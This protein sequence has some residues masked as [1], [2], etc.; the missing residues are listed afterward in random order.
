[1]KL[2][3]IAPNFEGSD[4]EFERYAMKSMYYVCISYIN[5]YVNNPELSLDNL[6]SDPDGDTVL[7]SELVED[8]S[9]LQGHLDAVDY[10]D[11][12]EG[13]KGSKIAKLFEL[14]FAHGYSPEEIIEKFPELGFKSQRTIFRILR[15]R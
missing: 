9:D 7:F 5:R 10:L 8:L 15:D 11:K 13:L 6:T 14:Y 1:M 3:T 2:Y 12:L 4:E